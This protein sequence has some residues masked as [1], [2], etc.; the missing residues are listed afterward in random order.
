[1]A[2]CLDAPLTKTF[3]AAIDVNFETCQHPRA[4]RRI[5]HRNPQLIG[6]L[7]LCRL[8]IARKLFQRTRDPLVI[9]LGIAGGVIERECGGSV[10]LSLG[11]QAPLCQRRGNLQ[12]ERQIL[13]PTTKC[14][15]ANRIECP[16]VDSSSIGLFKPWITGRDNTDS[17]P[18]RQIQI[19]P[20]P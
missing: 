18:L 13:A 5:D 10:V 15:R 4:N 16:P 19:R 11:A 7:V 12:I 8:V 1:M 2:I 3:V 9:R 6:R 14:V 20:I 17:H